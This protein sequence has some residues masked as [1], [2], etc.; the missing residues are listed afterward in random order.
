VKNAH[1]DGWGAIHTILIEK[2]GTA[3]VKLRIRLWL[4]RPDDHFAAA[5]KR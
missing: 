2:S 3:T 4:R 5:A 1:I